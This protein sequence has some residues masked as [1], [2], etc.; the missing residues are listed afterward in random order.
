MIAFWV[1]LLDRAIAFL[2]SLNGQFEQ[3][4]NLEL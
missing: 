1:S 3:K 4:G 2:I